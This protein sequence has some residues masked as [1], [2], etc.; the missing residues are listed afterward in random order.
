MSAALSGVA[1]GFLIDARDPRAA[2]YSTPEPAA[3]GLSLAAWVAAGFLI[4]C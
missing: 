3:A 1:V 4:G 2:L